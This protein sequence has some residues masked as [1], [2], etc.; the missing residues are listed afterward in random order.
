MRRA[1]I[2]ALPSPNPPPPASRD[3]E[4]EQ[5]AALGR[6]LLGILARRQ[7]QGQSETATEPERN[8]PDAR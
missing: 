2:I 6:V 5:W 8:A 1:K 7:V 4:H 3:R